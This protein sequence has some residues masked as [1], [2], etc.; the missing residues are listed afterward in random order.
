MALSHEQEY[1]P[2]SFLECSEGKEQEAPRVGGDCCEITLDG[3]LGQL[4]GE[5]REVHRHCAP[6]ESGPCVADPRD[7]D[8]PSLLFGSVVN[9]T[10]LILTLQTLT[11]SYY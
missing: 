7:T 9:C 6:G 8:L 2:V 4:I 11:V 3:R 5:R 10:D 1:C